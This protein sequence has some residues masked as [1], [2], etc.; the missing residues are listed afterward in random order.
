MKINLLLIGM[1]LCNAGAYAQNMFSMASQHPADTNRSEAH[2][3]AIR[4]P[5]L[6][7]AAVTVDLFG[8]GHFDSRFNGRDFAS[9]KSR[10][11]RISSRG[12]LFPKAQ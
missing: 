6:R 3:Q 11:A 4:F 2:E 5:S 8:S 9:G 10:N 7:Q 12:Q 1:F